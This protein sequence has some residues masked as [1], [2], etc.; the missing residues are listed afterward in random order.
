MVLFLVLIPVI[1]AVVVCVCFGASSCYMFR[2]AGKTAEDMCTLKT[3]TEVFDIGGWW[4]DKKLAWAVAKQ[5]RRAKRARLEMMKPSV[6]TKDRVIKEHKQDKTK[7]TRRQHQEEEQRKQQQPQSD[8]INGNKE[9]PKQVA[10]SGA[11]VSK[12]K[13][14]IKS[15]IKLSSARTNAAKVADQ[16]KK[17]YGHNSDDIV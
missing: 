8:A 12:D 15:Q 10:A 1:I 9:A 7:W 13:L 2:R 5:D 6:Q 14:K 17:K 4:K 3:W 16:M 11:L